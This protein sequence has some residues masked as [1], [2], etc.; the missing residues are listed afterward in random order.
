MKELGL[1]GTNLCQESVTYLVN[2]LTQN[3]LK[4]DLSD[5]KCISEEDVIILVK[6]CN[7][8]T[9]L[10]LGCFELTNNSLKNIVDYLK[11]TL[12]EL[13]VSRAKIDVESPVALKCLTRLR[14][15]NRCVFNSEEIRE[16]KKHI[17]TLENV[18]TTGAL[19]IAYSGQYT[20][21]RNVVDTEN[22]LNRSLS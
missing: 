9:A 1:S 10:N 5:Q 3:I 7:K 12:E 8:L 13:Q 14:I 18:N 4:L 16:L 19:N 6:R 22:S 2:N 21:Y 11:S 15:L 20:K 17:P